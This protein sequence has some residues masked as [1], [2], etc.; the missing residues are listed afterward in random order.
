[1][2][3]RLVL[4]ED[5]RDLALFEAS[6]DLLVLA[7]TAISVGEPKRALALLEAAEP[8]PAAGALWH[9]AR[10]QDLNWFPGGAGA[11]GLDDVDF[12]HLVVPAEAAEATPAGDLAAYLLVHVAAELPGRRSIARDGGGLGP[13]MVTEAYEV[14]LRVQ[15]TGEPEAI[16]PAA[17]ALASLVGQ[18]GGPL[19]L[20]RTAYQIAGDQAGEAACRLAEGD[21]AAH[22]SRH[23]ELLDEDLEPRTAG[24][25]S[26]LLDPAAAEEHY[27][28]AE[29]LYAAAGSRRGAAAVALRRAR[30]ALAA[31]DPARAVSLLDSAGELAEAAGDGALHALILVQHALA[32]I[33]NGGRVDA[34]RVAGRVADWAKAVGSSSFARGLCR[35]A[36]AKAGRWRTEDVVLGQRALAVAEAIGGRIGATAESAA[37]DRERGELYVGANYRPAALVWTML[38]VAEARAAATGELSV[39]DWARL[40]ERLL[41][42]NRDANAAGDPGAMTDVREQLEW[43]LTRTPAELPEPAGEVLAPVHDTITEAAVLVPLY[44]GVLARL[45]GD[46][47]VAAEHFAAAL[48]E[49]ERLGRP[50]LQAVV[51]G[52]MHR[53]DEAAAVIEPFLGDFPPDIAA[54]FLIRLHRYQ[55][56][57]DIIEQSPPDDP[58]SLERPW[59]PDA[60]HAEALLGVGRAEQAAEL[61]V[62]AIAR[63]EEHLGLL[64]RDVLRVMA[65]DDNTVAGLYATGVR[66]HAAAD[67]TAESFRLAG[68][69]RGA[70]LLDLL[71]PAVTPGEEVA[72]AVRD[73]QRAGAAFG[74]TVERLARSR[75]AGEPA[76]TRH[77]MVTAERELDRA[78]VHMITVA[79]ELKH[80]RV[81]PETP[82]LAEIQARLRPGTLLIEC[83]A[84]DDVLTCWAVT[85]T[86]ARVV[87][88]DAPTPQLTAAVR[89]FHRAIEDRTTPPARR[90]ELGRPLAELLLG[91]F[92]P[93]LADHGRV[94]VVPYGGLSVLPVHVLPFGADL[95]T[96]DHDVSYLPSS[97]L[98]P[99]AP[100]PPLGTD[101]LIVGN[102]AYA[103]DRDLMRLP[104]AEVEA[105]TIARLRAQQVL[106]GEEATGKAVLDRMLTARVV[107]LATHGS[108]AEGAPYS[109]ELALAGPDSLTVPDLMGLGTTID[110]AILSACD[111]GRGRAGS[112]GDVVGLTRAFLGAGVRELIVSLWP[113]HDRIACLTMVALHRHLLAGAPTAVALA[114]AQRETRAMTEPEANDLYRALEQ[115]AGRDD[116]PPSTRTRHIGPD[117]DEPEVPGIDHPFFWAPF[118]HI[119]S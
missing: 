96:T 112:A 110:L 38:V 36:Y 59:E 60:R 74:R 4:R 90:R 93:E 97:S 16:A 53:R 41:R 83:H 39:L 116:G 51:L 75:K 7:A 5:W 115:Q 89:R 30:L 52:T 25:P 50:L 64:A 92:A 46:L 67:R 58:S 19:D 29:Q 3:L 105:V 35:L 49:A 56:A 72:S 119:G 43:L 45:G 47:T 8:G 79:P 73:W 57:L 100:P 114:Q 82:S 42:A 104:G 23:P 77:E 69:C 109:A 31:G 24:R 34:D 6:D 111:S 13:Q 68:R 103:P 48:A 102:P 65:T 117:I 87:Q 28:A 2:L 54:N 108:L 22:P 37:F 18:P 86:T 78:E 107:H 85:A 95:L 80:R 12:S 61:A 88:Q 55:Q 11:A 32:T 15:E 101:A 33:R 70:S 9:L 40:A 81:L 10:V 76:V 99:S 106:R 84:F 20:A 26:A 14:L 62:T 91:P 94:V 27:A 63:F 1:M 71:E 44:R 17:Y 113:V 66:A 118:I 21:W 98:I